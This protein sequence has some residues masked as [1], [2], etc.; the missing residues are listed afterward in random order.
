MEYQGLELEAAANEVIEKLTALGG[1]GG[2]IALDAKGNFA[3][4]F[5]TEGMYRGHVGEDGE[6]HVLFYGADEE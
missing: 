2:I 3:M 6:V 1:D 5:N 4:S